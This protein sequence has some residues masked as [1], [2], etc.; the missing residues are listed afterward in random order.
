MQK[1]IIKT[2]S[3]WG[4]WYGVWGPIILAFY[5]LSLAG[6]ATVPMKES[7]AVYNI[8]GTTYLPLISLCE[9][10]GINWEYDTFGRTVILSKGA[11]RINLM[12]GDTLVLVDGESTHLKYPVQLYQGTPAVPAKFKEQV[13]D[14]LF[15]EAPA[16]AQTRVVPLRIKK[17]VIDAGH[18]GRDPGAIGH[19]GLREKDVTLDIAKRL[20]NL[21]RAQGIEVVMTRSTDRFVELSSRVDIANSCGADLFLSIHANANRVRSLSGFE[22]YYVSPTVDDAQRA[23]SSAREAKLDFNGISSLN[24]KAT[25][26]DMIYT[27]NRAQSIELSRY[28]C[29]TTKNTLDTNILGIKGARFYVL[30]G[31]RM[32]AILIEIGFLSNY[33]EERM[34][35]NSYYRQKI[36]E[37]IISGVKSFAQDVTLAQAFRQ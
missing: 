25:L 5:L 16:P 1:T 29:R 6:C 37:C 12:V 27:S 11:H 17:I 26:W 32:P 36:V 22:I 18:G 33:S 20:K 10:K 31:T 34:L 24:L 13:L 35:R 21:L 23:V 2:S 28:I 30:K 3:F 9:S 14:I 19:S 4:L 7:L 8:N 15:K